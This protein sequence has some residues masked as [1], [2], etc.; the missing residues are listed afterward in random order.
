MHAMSD[1][2]FP[3]GFIGAIRELT[4]PCVGSPDGLHKA[5][6]GIGAGFGRALIDL[7]KWSN[8]VR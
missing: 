7:D 3:Y 6:I 5:G 4:D 8:R 1:S 2:Q